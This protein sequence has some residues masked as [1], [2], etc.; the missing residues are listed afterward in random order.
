MRGD[1]EKLQAELYQQIGQLKVELD[2]VK[3]KLE[4][5]VDQ[6]R[7]LIEP[8]YPEISISRQCALLGLPRSSLS[9]LAFLNTTC[10]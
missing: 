6:N 4:C 10:C 3:K 2:W 7:Y 1:N 5:S 9:L 8:E